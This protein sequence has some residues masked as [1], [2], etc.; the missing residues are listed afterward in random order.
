VVYG[1]TLAK[2]QIALGKQEILYVLQ[3]AGICAFAEILRQSVGH[4]QEGI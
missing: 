1:R 4:F 3:S 2:A